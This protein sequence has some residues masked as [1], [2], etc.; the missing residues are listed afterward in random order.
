MNTCLRHC[1][2]TVFYSYMNKVFEELAAHLH[3]ASGIDKPW[4]R[5][6]ALIWLDL[7]FD[8]VTS[9]SKARLVSEEDVPNSNGLPAGTAVMQ[10]YLQEYGNTTVAYEDIRPFVQKLQPVERAN[11]LD[12]LLC[13]KLD[14]SYK[15]DAEEMKTIR[16]SL[17]PQ[18]QDVSK[19]FQFNDF[20]Y[21]QTHPGTEY[22]ANISSSSFRLTRSLE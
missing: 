22:A 12:T 5:N 15:A 13:N 8:R 19:V 10:H 17:S 20:T 11:L 6:A 21:F 18:N 3:P 9:V 14:T 7:T 2:L 16:R 4:R 1:L